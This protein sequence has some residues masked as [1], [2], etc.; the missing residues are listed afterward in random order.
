MFRALTGAVLELDLLGDL[1]ARR[2]TL[3]RERHLDT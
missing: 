2:L 1:A 3:G